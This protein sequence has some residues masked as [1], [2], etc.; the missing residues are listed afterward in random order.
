M[1][2]FGTSRRRLSFGRGPGSAVSVSRLMPPRIHDL[3]SACLREQAVPFQPLLAL[4]YNAKDV[5]DAR[6]E[7]AFAPTNPGRCEDGI[8]TCGG[9]VA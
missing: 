5:T 8:F 7:S 2:N 1:R 4:T 6:S 3:R 9:R